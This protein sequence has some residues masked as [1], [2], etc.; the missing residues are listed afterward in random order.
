MQSFVN[1]ELDI[2]IST[3]MVEVGVNVPNATCMVIEGAD[4]F[5]LSQLHQLRGRVGRSTHKSACFLFSSSFSKEAGDR[6]R[7][8]ANTHDGFA[9][10]E[11]DAERRGTGDLY[12]TAQSGEGELFR[13]ANPRDVEM[14]SM[15]RSLVQQENVLEYSTIKERLLLWERE[16]HLE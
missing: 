13:F 8:F 15:V 10:A 7:F 6:L 2:L 12:G 14:L 5:G 1:G 3:P 11:Y 16:T 4:R 9:I